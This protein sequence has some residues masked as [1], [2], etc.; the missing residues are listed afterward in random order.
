MSYKDPPPPLPPLPHRA[1]VQASRA[2][3]S[4]V[5]EMAFCI[6]HRS[7][8]AK[9]RLPLVARRSLSAVVAK[10]R[11]PFEG[12]R[13]LEKA[14]LLSGRLTGFRRLARAACDPER[15][16]LRACCN[17]PLGPPSRIWRPESK[18]RSRSPIGGL[19]RRASFRRLLE[20][21]VC[22]GLCFCSLC[23]SRA[24]RGGGAEKRNLLAPSPRCS[25]L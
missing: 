12:V 13:V 25:S 24:L 5:R 14:N 2:S 4:A 20:G 22:W 6:P 3:A 23:V 1:S 18:V 11:L 9:P 17:S 7:R 21:G 10:P 19:A 16:G 8:L 15:G